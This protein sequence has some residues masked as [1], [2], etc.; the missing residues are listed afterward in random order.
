MES[1]SQVWKIVARWPEILKSIKIIVRP[2]CFPGN[3]GILRACFNSYNLL[4]HYS[5]SQIH[6]SLFKIQ[7]RVPSSRFGVPS[8][9]SKLD[10]RV[11]VS[12]PC[13]NIEV[14]IPNMQVPRCKFKVPSSK[15]REQVPSSHFKFGLPSSGF[16]SK[17]QV[18]VSSSDSDIE[19]LGSKFP[20]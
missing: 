13:S 4:N 19:I 15:L 2:L 18:H 17:S 14:P 5:T 6:I 11:H 8:S 10:F 3:V 7:L 9:S 12:I 20:V 16:K 1:A